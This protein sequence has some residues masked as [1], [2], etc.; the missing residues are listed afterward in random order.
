VPRVFFAVWPDAAA[1]EA[2]AAAGR[3]ARKTSGGRPMRPETLHLTLAFLGEQPAERLAEAMAVAATRAAAP[4]TLTL[5]RLGYWQ[6]NRILW[7]GGDCPPLAALADGLGA[8]LRAAGFRLDAR[9]FAIH[10]TLLRDARCPA[11]PAL[12][13]PIA[14]PVSEFVLVESRLSAAGADYRVIGR[15]P[16]AA[17]LDYNPATP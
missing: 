3:D 7:A 17:P 12:A 5:D 13:A 2:M 4:F 8:A 15:W 1:A 6:H 16:L 11:P 14:W 10:A 9:P